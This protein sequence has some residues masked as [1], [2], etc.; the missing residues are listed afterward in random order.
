MTR[1]SAD[2]TTVTPPALPGDTLDLALELLETALD[3]L[4]RREG[5]SSPVVV[6]LRRQSLRLRTQS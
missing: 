6:S 1:T 4:E 2:R 3:A 5:T